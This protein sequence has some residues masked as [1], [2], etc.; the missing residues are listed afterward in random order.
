VTQAADRVVTVLIVDDH[1]LLAQSLAVALGA[2]GVPADVADLASRQALIE[3]VRAAP[4]PLVLLDL[5]LGGAVGDGSTLVRPFVQAGSRVLVVSGT[6]DV[7][8]RGTALEQGAMGLVHKSEPFEDLLAKT[9]AAA[10]GA[11]VMNEA[12][13][14]ALIG[15]ARDARKGR[16]VLREPFDRLTPREQ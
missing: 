8:R 6:D 5:E 7:V 13:R 3:G 10:S 12:E 9:L 14:Q 2:E 15:A 11:Q 16:E 1:Q 4:P